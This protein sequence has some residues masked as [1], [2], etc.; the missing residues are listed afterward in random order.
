MTISTAA[1]AHRTVTREPLVLASICAA[2]FVSHFHML[3]LPPLF[4][5]LKEALQVSYVELGLALT[6][7]NVVSACTQAPVGFLA[8][9]IGPA[10]LL[11]VGLCLAG[12]AFA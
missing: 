4:P 1:E 3:I 9:R 8:D 10:R 7:F 12:A 2:H 5:V 11:V 6:A